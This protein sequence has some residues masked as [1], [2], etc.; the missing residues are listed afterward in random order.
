[1]E[2][3]VIWPQDGN[4]IRSCTGIQ[5]KSAAYCSRHKLQIR[6]G[7]SGRSN[8]VPNFCIIQIS[9]LP[10]IFAPPRRR[11]LTLGG[12]TVRQR[13]LA[14]PVTYFSKLGEIQNPRIKFWTMTPFTELIFNKLWEK[15]LA[16]SELHWPVQSFT[17]WSHLLRWSKITDAP[18]LLAFY[19]IPYLLQFHY[20]SRLPLLCN[21]KQQTHKC[22]Y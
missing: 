21:V 7:E 18:L 9:H 8:L 19:D 15:A 6:R 16:R 11:S 3:R 22:G 17:G 2:P 1:M 5:A 4:C 20:C 12:V 14:L 13:V 10:E